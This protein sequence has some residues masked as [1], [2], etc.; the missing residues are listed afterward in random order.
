VSLGA[1]LGGGLVANDN[2]DRQLAM[3]IGENMTFSTDP[4]SETN[5]GRSRE[6]QVKLILVIL[7]EVAIII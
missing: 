2:E 5:D 4:A 6:D 1:T 3:S 7:P